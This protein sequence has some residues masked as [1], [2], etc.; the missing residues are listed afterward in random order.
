MVRGWVRHLFIINN[1]HPKVRHYWIII[2][3]CRPALFRARER[4]RDGGRVKA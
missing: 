4:S 2:A 1:L 3:S